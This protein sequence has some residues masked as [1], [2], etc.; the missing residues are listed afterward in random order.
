MIKF[1]HTEV[2]GFDHAIRGARNPMDSWDRS[3]S[4][5][6]YIE[7]ADTHEMVK[8]EYIIGEQD[9][10]LLKKL[11]AAGTD[12]AKF[13]RFINVY[14]DITAPLYWLKEMDTYRMGV[15]K[16]SC[17]TMHTI[18]KKELTVDNFSHDRCESTYALRF[19]VNYINRLR[20]RYLETKDKRYWYTIIQNLPSSFNQRRTYM[21]SYQAL[22]NMYHA[23]KNHKLD[24]WRDFCAWIETLP[25]SELITDEQ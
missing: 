5:W 12:H 20:D 15:E 6:G 7:A 23:R 3:D 1:E 18:H 13:M 16:N 17:S 21:I 10:K 2:M 22:H 4:L 9:L 11:V 24:E 14:V 25:Y 8:Y 19:L